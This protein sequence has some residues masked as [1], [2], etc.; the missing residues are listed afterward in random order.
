MKRLQEFSAVGLAV[1]LTL[2][3]CSKSGPSGGSGIGELA[4]K[5]KSAMGSPLDPETAL[6]KSAEAMREAKSWRMKMSM[7]GDKGESVQLESEVSCPDRHHSRMN[8]AGRSLETYRI[9]DAAYTNMMGR[10]TKMPTAGRP[11]AEC[12]RGEAAEAA[13]GR[14]GKEQFDIHEVL[15]PG[16]KVTGGGMGQSGGIP[17]QL[18][19]VTAP[20]RHGA[21]E[22]EYSICI[23]LVDHLPRE[24]KSADGRMLVTYSDWNSP[25]AISPPI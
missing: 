7:T 6:K 20:S 24:M 1:I 15:E 13:P 12:A 21:P 2:A 14:R 16:A 8:M 10:W 4:E 11:L 22:M 25:I 5:A 3:G 9:G 18:I 23:G 17:C 19:K